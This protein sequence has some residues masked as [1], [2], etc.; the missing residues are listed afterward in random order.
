MNPVGGLSALESAKILTNK[1]LKMNVGEWLL[2]SDLDGEHSGIGGAQRDEL[3]LQWRTDMLPSTPGIGM[4][5]DDIRRR[6][7]TKIRRE[8]SHTNKL[9]QNLH[10]A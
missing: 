1:R 6:S 3:D 9:C 10:P 2:G 4:L 7:E 8:R 5:K